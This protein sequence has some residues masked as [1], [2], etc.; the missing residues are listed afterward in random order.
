MALHFNDINTTTCMYMQ[1]NSMGVCMYYQV[2]FSVYSFIL[3]SVTLELYRC[4]LYHSGIVFFFF[5]WVISVARSLV[6]RSLFVPLFPFSWPL[7]C[8]F[9]FD[10]RILIT[11]LVFQT[12]L[13][14]TIPH[15]GAYFV[16]PIFQ[17]V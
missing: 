5:V 2:T 9:F 12:N 11:P 13:F 1:Y 15:D 7:S 8:L 6:Y 16:L 4:L 17:R 14:S 3:N 10:L